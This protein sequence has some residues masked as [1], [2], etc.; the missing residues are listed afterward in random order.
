MSACELSFDE[1]AN[2]LAYGL[3]QDLNKAGVSCKGMDQGYNVINHAGKYCADRT[4]R[5]CVLSNGDGVLKAE[6]VLE[7]ALGRYETY[8]QVIEG[9]LGSPL[10]WVLDD[11]DPN[12]A[13]DADIRA[14]VTA[15]ISG[16]KRVI[17]S[18]GIKEGTPKYNGALAAGLTWFVAAPSHAEFVELKY[19]GSPGFKMFKSGMGKEGLE[20]FLKYLE[21][22]GGLRVEGNYSEE[23]T[24]LDALKYNQGECTEQ[25][26]ILPKR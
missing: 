4:A 8:R 26:V 12:T 21:V 14:K 6:E 7:Y 18:N 9:R 2:E 15:A 5:N 19:S 23:Y 3:Y 17:V 16:L 10:P 1:K 11:L 20:K 25:L 22:K 24:A 13:F